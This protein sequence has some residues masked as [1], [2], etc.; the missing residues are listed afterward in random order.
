M[1][2]DIIELFRRQR[3]LAE[4]LNAVARDAYGQELAVGDRVRFAG[5]AVA[6]GTVFAIDLVARP[7]PM[8]MVFGPCGNRIAACADLVLVAVPPPAASPRAQADARVEPGHDG[9]G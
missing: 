6:V 2:A 1:T 9:E 4:P 7:V 8:A 3:P 5:D